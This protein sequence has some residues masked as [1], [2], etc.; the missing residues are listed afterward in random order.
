MNEICDHHN[1]AEVLRICVECKCAGCGQ[2][3]FRKTLEECYA[4]GDKLIIHG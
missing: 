4:G 2:I 3:K 1:C